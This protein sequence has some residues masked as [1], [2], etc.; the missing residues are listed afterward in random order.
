LSSHTKPNQPHLATWGDTGRCASAEKW[1]RLQIQRTASNGH[2]AP[3]I[4]NLLSE[5]QV[6]VH[7]Q[8]P[9]RGKIALHEAIRCL[10]FIEF[11]CEP[12]ELAFRPVSMCLC[13]RVCVRVLLQMRL[14]ACLS[15]VSTYS[16]AVRFSFSAAAAPAHT[17]RGGCA[18]SVFFSPR[19]FRTCVPSF[20]GSD[21]S[22][23]PSSLIVIVCW[24]LRAF[25][26]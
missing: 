3:R 15:H 10:P 16:C 25:C 9:S 21:G 22:V 7:R 1:P 4:T 17:L 24:D 14:W 23:G 20:M 11:A 19:Y 12:T 13:V 8:P 2:A 18:P 26:R 5:L 6:A